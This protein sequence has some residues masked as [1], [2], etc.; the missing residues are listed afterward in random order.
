MWLRRMQRSNYVGKVKEGSAE[1]RRN[2]GSI[3]YIWQI[4]QIRLTGQAK[5]C[6]FGNQQYREVINPAIRRTLHQTGKQVSKRL[7]HPVQ[8]RPVFPVFP[9]TQT[10]DE[11][12][13]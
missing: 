13:Q 12:N 4:Y 5:V 8:H 2:V 3:Y 1:G 11:N 9:A 6:R 10:W 7:F